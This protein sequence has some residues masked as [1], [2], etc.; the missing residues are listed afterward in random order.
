MYPIVAR[1][2]SDVKRGVEQAQERGIGREFR[3]TLQRRSRGVQMAVAAEDY[4]QALTLG[5]ERRL[6]EGFQVPSLHKHNVEPAFTKAF[7]DL[8]GVA[9]RKSVECRPR[10]DIAQKIITIPG[11]QA[12]IPLEF[13]AKSGFR[14]ISSG[15]SMGKKDNEI[16]PL[17][18]RAKE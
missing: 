9:A 16:E 1:A 17:R 6:Q 5:G 13:D 12:N 18:E 4:R 2:I 11:E 7:A 3:D 15:R 8:R 10:C 14:L